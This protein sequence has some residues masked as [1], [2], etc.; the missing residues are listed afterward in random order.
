V[1][2]SGVLILLIFFG[3][4]EVRGRRFIC[5]L[6]FLSIVFDTNTLEF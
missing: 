3:S 6:S 5:Q 4:D 1:S 2:G